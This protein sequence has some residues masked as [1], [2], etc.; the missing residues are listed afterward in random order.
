[1]ARFSTLSFITRQR[2]RKIT[3]HGSVLKYKLDEIAY[4]GLARANEWNNLLWIG[5][6]IGFLRDRSFDEIA[7]LGRAWG[8]TN[9]ITW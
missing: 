3:F 5:F 7:Y 6:S 1:M 9:G 8:K 2:L 4:L